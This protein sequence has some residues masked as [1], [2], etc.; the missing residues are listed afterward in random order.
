MELAL[1]V[2]IPDNVATPIPSTFPIMTLLILSLYVWPYFSTFCHELGHFVCA[3]LVGMTP[4][5]MKVGMSFSVSLKHF[6]GARLELGILPFGGQTYAYYPDK[7]WSKFEDLKLK[8]II[9]I[10]GGC[11]ANFVLLA[12]S[13]MML[14]YTGFPIFIYFIYVESVMI[15]T[16]LVPT[17]GSLYGMKFPS[18]GKRIFFIITQNYQRFFFA[19]HQ[20]EIA[21]IAGDR[22]EPQIFFKNDIKTLGLFVKAETELAYRH[23]DE[24]ITLLNQLLNAENA[25]DLERAYLLNLLASI[26]ISH[27]QKQYLTRADGWSQ[28]AMKL[29]SHSKAIQGTRGA[30][31]VELG[32]HEEGKQILL[33]LTKPGN[34][35]I[36][37]AICSYYL[38]K[39]DHC[40]GNSEQAR[41]WLKQAEQVIKKVPGLPEMFAS[42]KQEL[43]VSLN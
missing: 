3:K 18:D 10:I 12:Y 5:L 32:R 7:G 42:I 35:P 2:T 38:A 39:A 8:L 16:A 24:A 6:F 36:D 21:R 28:E 14:V 27:G 30:I 17:Y 31:L 34:D 41:R 9:Y 26:V 23:F 15:I 43:R 29:A 11:L 13:I 22:A 25:F 33:P 1:S 37:I 40:L 20:K 19:D 4:Q